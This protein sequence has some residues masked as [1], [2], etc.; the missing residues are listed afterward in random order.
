MIIVGVL[1]GL[2]QVGNGSS[3]FICPGHLHQ[4]GAAAKLNVKRIKDRVRKNGN[5]LLTFF[6]QETFD[7]S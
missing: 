6:F 3:L 2:G 7:I 5:K 4:A 1:L